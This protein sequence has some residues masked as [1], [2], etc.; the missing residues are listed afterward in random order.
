MNR[1]RTPTKLAALSVAFGLLL[2]AC[3]MPPVPAA[4][5]PPQIVEVTREVPVEVTPAPVNYGEV[6][7]LSTQLRPVGEAERVRGVILRGFPGRVDFVP[8]D[9][10]PFIDRIA[11]ET[12]AGQG[13]VSLLG[14][15]H[16][17]FSS[18]VAANQ[19]MDLTELKG[20]LM[21]RGIP[22]EFWKLAQFGTDKT[23][24]VPW[25]QATYTLVAN[26]KA[27]E[28]LP[29][30]ADMNA[31]TYAQLLEWARNMREATQENKLGIPA[32]ESALLHRFF[33]GFL[34]PAFTGG[35]VTTYASED[36]ERAWQYMKDLWE[37][38]NPQALTY[39][40]MQDHLLAE[41]VWVAWDHVARTK[42]ALEQRPDDFVALPVPAGPKGRASMPV[43][44]G[45]GIPMTAPNVA[46]AEALIE[47]L[48]QPDT[49]IT[50][51]REVG[52]FPMVD[53]EFPGFV[54]P[55]IRAQGEV[56]LKQAN[57]PDALAVLL[58]VGL[59]PKN[60]D[61]NKIFR[62]TFTAIVI[63]DE[64]I[65]ATLASQKSVLNA[66]MLEVGAPCWAPDP[67]S[68]G[69]PCQAK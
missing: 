5:Q 14:A 43:I 39:N 26:K 48:T 28:Y 47:F 15:L 45:L 33:Q 34:L 42:D 40:F 22:D 63:N 19:L 55:G 52:F 31:L 30:G 60:G 44:A 8:E 29:E 50:T 69:Q 12:Q 35:V 65:S 54:T 10:G 6:V 21:D 66:L 53:V 59:G 41:E 61:F 4:Q 24:Y 18:M 23:Y 9:E 20:R 67:D 68:N 17:N 2:A 51:L 27:L 57:A 36:A 32:G 16:G 13:T 46:G 11:A 56:V 64:D 58:P 38:V 7:W 62:D 3:Q 1:F 49:Q 37:Y 25:M